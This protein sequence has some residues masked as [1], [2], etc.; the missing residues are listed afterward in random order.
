MPNAA[1]ARRVTVLLDTHVLAWL[2]AQPDR[3]R[4][5]VREEIAMATVLAVSAAT[6]FEFD[7]LARRGR[8][9]GVATFALV[10]SHLEAVVL[11]LPADLW[12]VAAALP[13]IHRDPVD[14]MLIAH[15][16]HADLTLVTADETM[17]RYPVRS[18]W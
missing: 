14:R 15:A 5:A 12:R 18:L 7:D 4:A 1:S 16:I 13:D 6:A 11:P 10:E 3:I 9:P 2:I 8:L 17:R